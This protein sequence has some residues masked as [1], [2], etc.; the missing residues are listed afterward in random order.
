[1]K[2]LVKTNVLLDCTGAAP[3][4]K[5][6]LLFDEKGIIT[7]VGK[8]GELTEIDG[9]TKTLDFSDKFVMPGMI[10][11]H[12]HFSLSHSDSIEPMPIIEQFDA[13][14]GTRLCKAFM[15]V[16]EHIQGGVTVFRGMGDEDFIDFDIKHAIEKGY[17]R[18]PR[19][20]PCGHLVSATNGHGQTGRIVA[21]GV[22]GVRRLCRVNLAKGAELIK[23]IVG[24][25]V[26][27]G[28]IPL[29]CTTY[30]AEEVRCAVEEAESLGKYV[31]SHSI[32]GLSIDLCIDEGVRCLEHAS[33][34]TDEQIERIYKTG[35]WVTGTFSPVM[36]PKGLHD[37]TPSRQ[38][39]L[40]QVKVQ[41]METFRKYHQAGV[42]M[43]FGTDGVH[44]G[45]ALEAECIAQ[46]GATPQQ[47][48]EYITREASKSCCHDHEYG[49]LEPGKFAD[50]IALEK[51]PLEDIKNLTTV[52]ECYIGGIDQ[53][54]Y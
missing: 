23:L 22:E 18:G 14:V 35:T 53:L 25:G 54:R 34:V 40:E 8:P 28:N 17:F 43:C 7:A 30:R 51:N 38:A 32:G 47:A 33:M 49:T 26:A 24:G 50:F 42:K 52:R 10:D 31:A 20:I 48:I 5:G 9:V 46:C 11:A 3:L 2:T 44:G 4:E 39:R 1:M 29:H 19:V 16:R 27:T 21:D 15:Y 13:P 41:M 45:M 12:N 37:L 6:W 36:S